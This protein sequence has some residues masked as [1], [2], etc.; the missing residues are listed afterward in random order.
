MAGRG[1]HDAPTRLPG[2]SG[3]TPSTGLTGAAAASM[4]R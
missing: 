1:V 2:L 3:P 4:R